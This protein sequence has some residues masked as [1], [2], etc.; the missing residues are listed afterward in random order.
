[1]IKWLKNKKIAVNYF[2]FGFIFFYLVILSIIHI[3]PLHAVS[4]KLNILFIAQAI[5]QSFAEILLLLTLFL[6]IKQRFLKSLYLGLLFFIVLMHFINHF[7]IHLM[8]TNL[9]FIFKM[10]FGAGVTNLVTMIKAININLAMTFL[11][12]AIM[13]ITPVVGTI[14]YNV[15]HHLSQKKPLEISLLHIVRAFIVISITFVI[16]DFS[17]KPLLSSETHRSYEKKLPLGLTFFKPTPHFIT[18]PSPI[19]KERDENKSFDAF[20]KKDFKLKRSPNIYL[21]IVETFREDFINDTVTPNI[22]KFKHNNIFFPY[23]FSNAN[24]SQISWYAIFHANFPYYWRAQKGQK[25][26]LPLHILKKLGYKINVYCSADLQYFQ[27]EQSLFGM[28]HTLIDNFYDFSKAGAPHQRDKIV[29]NKLIEDSKSFTSSPTIFI[30]FLD[31]PHSEYSWPQD[32]TCKF[33]PYS[34]HINYLKLC[35]I[36]EEL[37]LVKNSYRNS[38]YYVDTLFGNFLK[39]LPTKN[40]VIVITGDHGEEFFEQG[41]MFHATHINSLQTRV[42]LYYKFPGEKRPKNTM[43]CHMDIFPS[44]IH[45]VTGQDNFKDLFDGESIF[46]KDK[47]PYVVCV[48]HN[49][50]DTPQD[51]FIHTGEYKLMGYLENGLKTKKINVISIHDVNDRSIPSKDKEILENTFKNA[52]THLLH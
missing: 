28:N 40:D 46:K 43:T 14:I 42:P 23:S 27:M 20:A 16:L 45:Y 3:M 15:T 4:L 9:F 37:E 8:D 13:A 1:M 52:F 41:A 33:V 49:A 6:W 17:T 24:S 36:Q 31:S 30:T 47:W 50:G 12:L 21:F 18:L 25:G 34:T 5:L 10:F 48:K 38:I 29:I 7:L 19:K 44:I 2:Y 51:F 35:Y 22:N 11:A 39:N 32:E 26:S